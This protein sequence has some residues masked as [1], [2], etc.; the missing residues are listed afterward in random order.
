MET[1]VALT[2]GLG[3]FSA[4]GLLLVQEGG[5]ISKVVN[6]VK[7]AIIAGLSAS[8][9]VTFH[10]WDGQIWWTNS[11]HCGRISSAG[12]ASNWG[13]GVP[14]TPTLGTT[15]GDLPAG[16]YQVTATYVDAAGIES[17]APQAAVVSVD[18]TE[19]ITATFTVADPF[20]THVRY[21]I[22]TPNGDVLYFTKKVAVES[23]STTI[24][25]A[26]YSTEPLRTQFMRGPVPGGGVASYKDT[27]LT[28]SGEYL[29][30]SSGWSPH[31]FHTKS[32]LFKV[33]GN[34]RGVVGLETGIFVATD[35]GMWWIA[36]ETL[37]TMQKFQLDNEVYAYN[38][39]DK[40]GY[41]IPKLQTPDRVALFVNSGGLVVGLPSGQLLSATR[42]NYN[43]GTIGSKRAS[44]AV[45]DRDG[46]K[47]VLFSLS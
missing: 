19:D 10:E 7:T 32:E 43:V 14:P 8:L 16:R 28:W 42:F 20:A 22:T 45:T 18:G 29:Y 11:V 38:G 35:A 34:I 23:V 15:V 30:L 25:N 2:G 46:L 13:M 1:V 6:G 24:T 3:G 47:Q 17:G 21:Y 36:G 9:P 4:L 39:I 44:F 26:A 5:T 27:L 40:P 12:V 31:V 37:A 41:L 33:T